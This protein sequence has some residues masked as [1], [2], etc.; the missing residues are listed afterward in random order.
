MVRLREVKTRHE[1]VISLL[2]VLRERLLAIRAEQGEG[3]EEFVFPNMA[4]RYQGQYS[5]RISTDFTGLLKAYGIV[6]TKE[7]GEVLEGR[8]HR[9]NPKSFH[10]IRH[11][12]V[13][14]A[15]VNPQLTADMVREAVGHTS[16]AVERG[17]FAAGDAAKAKVMEV[18]N[19]A[20]KPATSDVKGGAA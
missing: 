18:L 17:Y 15:R 19:D 16:E 1:R 8:R 5:S 12:V 7:D 2:P 10:S 9:V 4:Q 3:V 13:S 14:F 11:S 20:V 6:D